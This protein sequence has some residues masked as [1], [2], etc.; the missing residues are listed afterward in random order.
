MKN[1]KIILIHERINTY[2]L[3]IRTSTISTTLVET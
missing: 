2:S 1:Y 3:K